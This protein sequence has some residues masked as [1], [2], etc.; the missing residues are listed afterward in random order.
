M[1]SART[2]P[3]IDVVVDVWPHAVYAPSRV[4]VVVRSRALRAFATPSTQQRPVGD[5][6][7]LLAAW[8]CARRR[9]A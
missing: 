8:T 3:H 2:P 6:C 9:A 5:A 1:W 4:L 7:G